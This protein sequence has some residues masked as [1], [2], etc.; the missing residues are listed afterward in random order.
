M[1][2]LMRRYTFKLY[3]TQPQADQMVEQ[4]RMAASLWNSILERQ[5][6]L[7]RRTAGQAGVVHRG[8][9]GFVKDRWR[10]SAKA[11]LTFF[12]VT[13][14]ITKLRG[15]CPEWA[16]LSVWTAHRVA[17]AQ[18]LAFQAFFRRAKA[19]A[20]AQ[21]GYPRYRSVRHAD[22]LPHRFASGCRL[23]ARYPG[24]VG[25]KALHHWLA[26]K[27]VD[28]TIHCMGKFPATPMD[29]SDADI[30]LRDGTWWL[31]VGVEME[32]RR[33]AGRRDV[34]VRLDGL[35]FF[36]DVDG[37]PMSPAD[38]AGLV[39]HGQLEQI[40]ELQR[41]MSSMRRNDP[42]YAELRRRKGRLEAK[43][44]RR[45]REVLHAWTT[46]V[47]RRASSLLVVRPASVIEA[48]ES[49]RGDVKRWGAM[50]QTKAELNRH[51]LS[52]APA[53][54]ASML[55][56]KAEEAGIEHREIGH[57]ELLAGNELVRTAI[58][59]RKLRR[60]IRREELANA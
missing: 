40:V 56:Y 31:S 14:E 12:D 43:Q 16:A 19:G 18:D 57:D 32:C 28:G 55:R 6:E 48:T 42:E 51:I 37:R 26:L 35:D 7:Y 1:S 59:V 23:T 58:E 45:R 25:G 39:D 21:S 47:V 9:A 34:T 15:A 60:T 54:A 41:Q 20:G 46:D 13:A 44:A 24:A 36:A 49:G 17:R 8:D 2:M 4:C 50:V 38:V 11:R 29:W 5:E 52:Q 22:W 30:R 10:A 27:A 53:L 33:D 3:P